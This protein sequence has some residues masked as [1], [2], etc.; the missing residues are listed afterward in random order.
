MPFRKH[1]CGFLGHRRMKGFQ[2][3]GQKRAH[4]SNIRLIHT[5]G[6]MQAADGCNDS[7]YPK[8][9][10]RGYPNFVP[11]IHLQ[12]RDHDD[13]QE[14]EKDISGNVEGCVA[15]EKPFLVDA[16]AGLDGMVPSSIDG[17]GEEDVGQGGGDGEAGE[18]ADEDQADDAE[19]LLEEDAAVEKDQ[20]DAGERVGK[21]V[22][23]VEAEFGLEVK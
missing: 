19:P 2:R 11:R 6:I 14:E 1:R 9:K 10:D 5:I 22:E 8:P 3:E 16:V 13:W 4:T 23:D 18:N 20:G 21:V 15:N 17:D 12:P 7:Q